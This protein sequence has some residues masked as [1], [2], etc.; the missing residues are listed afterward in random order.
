MANDRLKN[1]CQIEHARRRFV[2][3]FLANLISGLTAYSFLEKKPYLKPEII[4]DEKLKKQAA[5]VELTLIHELFW[6]SL[7]KE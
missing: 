2:E 7:K 6:L 3:N 1:V 5:W 4:D